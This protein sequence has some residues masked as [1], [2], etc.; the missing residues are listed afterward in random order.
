MTV[1]ILTQIRPSLLC[2]LF[3]KMVLAQVVFAVCLSSCTS[4]AAQQSVP[5]GV[6]DTLGESHNFSE[7]PSVDGPFDS[8][9]P[10][11]EEPSEADAEHPEVAKEGWN[12][13]SSG[14][15]R[16]TWSGGSSFCNAHHTGFFCNSYTRI[17]CCKDWHGWYVQCGTTEHSTSCGWRGGSSAGWH[18][19]PGWHVSSYCE[20]HHVGTFCSSHRRIHCCNDYGHY[21]ECN[22]EYHDSSWC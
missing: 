18:I 9:G 12:T 13:S 21:V 20:S 4:A 17:R 14:L 16:G 2:W 7:V 15:L 11:Q 10:F 6:N 5:Q 3:C 19:H 8:E 22:S 1:A